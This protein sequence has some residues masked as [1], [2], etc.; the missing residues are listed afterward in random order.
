MQKVN[1]GILGLGKIADKVSGDI[2]LAEQSTI[3]AVASRSEEKAKAFARKFNAEKYFSTYEELV[4]CPDVDVVYVATPHMFHFE[5]AMLALK[6]GK[7][8]LCEK[9]MGMNEHQVDALIAKARKQKVFLMEGLWTRFIPATKKMLEWVDAGLIGEII[10]VKADFGF[11]AQFDPESRL[12]NKKLG[13]GSLL[14]IGIYPTYL[15]LLLLGLP[16]Q[17]KATARMTDTGVDSYFTALGEYESGAVATLESTIEADTPIEGYIY[18]TKGYIKMHSRFHH[19]QKLTMHIYDKEEESIELPY[20]G[21]GYVHEIDEVNSCV[22]SGR[23]ESDLLSLQT[24]RNLI[25]LLDQIRAKID[26]MY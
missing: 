26:L 10:S 5:H 18:G 13:G 4:Q 3:Y 9:P 8:V 1:W 16:K 2:V 19:T 15:S 6:N 21:E 14:D 17:I 11:K 24:S 25:R 12:F 20:L 22:L 7:H 23:K